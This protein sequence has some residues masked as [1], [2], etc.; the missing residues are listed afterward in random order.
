M[1]SPEVGNR[2]RL[3]DIL[4]QVAP[5]SEEPTRPVP[6]PDD[7]DRSDPENRLS[8]HSGIVAGQIRRN[9]VAVKRSG[10]GF[11]GLSQMMLRLTV[12]GVY[13]DPRSHSSL[14]HIEY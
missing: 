5:P 10:S 2:L 12:V 6:F 7:L 14:S 11:S 8:L 1:S 13:K 9:S 3:I 4:S